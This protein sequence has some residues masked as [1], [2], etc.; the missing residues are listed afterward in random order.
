MTPP[1]SNINE[2]YDSFESS[3]LY[4]ECKSYQLSKELIFTCTVSE[5]C[6]SLLGKH[7]FLY[8]QAW[9][10]VISSFGLISLSSL[11]TYIVLADP[12]E[13]PVISWTIFPSWQTCYSKALTVV[14]SFMGDLQIPSADISFS[15]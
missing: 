11:R 10:P 6:L 15:C 13:Q 12:A 1:D 5:S 9:V 2:L 14:M 7:L 4:T 8:R 3:S